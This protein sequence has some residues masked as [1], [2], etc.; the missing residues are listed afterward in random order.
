MGSGR[1]K[2][3]VRNHLVPVDARNGPTRQTV[4][5]SIGLRRDGEPR[6]LKR[7]ERLRRKLVELRAWKDAQLGA[8]IDTRIRNTDHTP[9]ADST[10][11]AQ[12]KPVAGTNWPTNDSTKPAVRVSSA[13]AEHGRHGQSAA[14]CD[15][16]PRRLAAH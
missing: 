14:E 8:A 12:R 16:R 2:R 13:A 7:L 3:D 6:A 1:R 5:H 4:T 15:I 10:F 9:R 11:I